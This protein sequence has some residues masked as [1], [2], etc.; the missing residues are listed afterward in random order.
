M[1][2]K[3]IFP[4]LV[5]VCITILFFYKTFLHGL[6]PFPGDL[7]ISEYQPW[8]N[9]SFL[10]YTPG[11][12][13][14]KKQYFDT[15]RQIY[16]WRT[17]VNQQLKTGSIPLWNPHNFSGQPLLANLQSQVFYPL[18]ILYFVLSQP[19]AWTTLVILQPMLASIGMFLYLTRLGRSTEASLLGAIS[20][21]FCSYSTV[22]LEYNTIGHVILWLPFILLS[23]ENIYFSKKI[24][25]SLSLIFCI[26]AAALAGHL[27][28]FGTIILFEL[29]YTFVIIRDKKTIA[30]VIFLTC[31][32]LGI[33]A[34][35]LFP[36]LE[37]LTQSARG[38]HEYT[39]MVG[40]LLIQPQQLF[41]FVNSDL[42]GN[43][44][45]G[46]YL[47]ADSY[48]GKALF[49]GSIV[50]FFSTVAV[51]SKKKSSQ[52]IFFTGIMGSL[53]LLITNNPLTKILYH[54][55]IPFISQS[56]PGNFIFIISFCGAVL[57]AFGIDL[58]IEK[59]INM[60]TAVIIFTILISVIWISY[61]THALLVNKTMLIMASGIYGVL[62]GLFGLSHFISKQAIIV[63]AFC[64]I[65]V[66]ELLYGFQKFNPFVPAD[67]VYPET[68]IVKTLQTE[69]SLY[70]FYGYGAAE[71]ESNF[72]TQLGLYDANGYDPLYPRYYGGL[73]ASSTEGVIPQNFDRS[74][75]SDA[76]V[77]PGFGDKAFDSNI[78][79]KKLIDLLGVRYILNTKE[80]GTTQN[81]FP[82][83]TYPVIN[84]EN[85]FFIHE[86][87]DVYPRAF[88]VPKAEPIDEQ[89]FAERFFSTNFNPRQTVLLNNI[90]GDFQ[91]VDE[92]ASG[93]AEIT[94]YTP[95]QIKID[96]ITTSPQWLVL[97]DTYMQGW[98]A[99]L[100]SVPTQIYQADY[101]F[102]SVHIPQG[103]HSIVFLYQPFSFR[104]G[105]KIS[106]LSLASLL[107]YAIWW[108]I[109]G[110]PR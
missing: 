51:L 18:T 99:Y 55:S 75:R 65:T 72:A 1:A 25:H 110:V 36:T 88:L 54:A 34:V 21:G 29:L 109:K 26:V 87:T 70:R 43:P 79:R 108:K 23:I 97:T 69:D 67:L 66:V 84:S 49:F 27:Q 8:K 107:I 68:S 59:K 42:F 50:F 56:G 37:L 71:I 48:P 20:Y 2:I 101:T 4:I 35:Q 103:S 81:T 98:D 44:A 9:Y 60:R 93:S 106:L 6:L 73:I 45:T 91:S 13:P 30:K 64:L 80:N 39:D 77:A 63:H 32:A 19:L 105:W 90:G 104:L 16:P 78:Y 74:I 46:N 5:L 86:N 83:D 52:V 82:P 3:K 11:S 96:T 12:F 31:V 22:F 41:T 47:L 85:N 15:I 94:I 53:L 89:H 38:N 14:S 40:R 28:I 62:F 100:D 10:G 7:L 61:L 92:Q 33:S 102:R 24:T 17:F 95:N 76:R 58:W 57:A